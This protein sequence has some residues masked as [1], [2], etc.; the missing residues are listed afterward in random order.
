MYYTY[1]NPDSG[2]QQFAVCKKINMS[3]NKPSTSQ[4][5]KNRSNNLREMLSYSMQEDYVKKSRKLIEIKCDAS[6]VPL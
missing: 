1:R 5:M 6:E 3:E 4:P 2:L